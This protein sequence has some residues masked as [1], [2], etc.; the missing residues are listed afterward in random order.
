MVI[1]F[2]EKPYSA[3]TSRAAERAAAGNPVHCFLDYR[4]IHCVWYADTEAGI[5]KT[6]DVLGDGKPHST[7]EL[8]KSD[9]LNDARVE[10]PLDGAVSMT[11]HGKVELR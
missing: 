4:E 6:F 5:V 10:A 7:R 8:L 2:R 11:L 1:N 3:E 9:V